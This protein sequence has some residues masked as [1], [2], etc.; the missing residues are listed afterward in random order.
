MIPQKCVLYLIQTV[1][2]DECQN[3]LILTQNDWC[4]RFEDSNVSQ[5]K[6][7]KC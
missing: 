2:I 1:Q 5:N 6:Y 3:V 4:V 7:F